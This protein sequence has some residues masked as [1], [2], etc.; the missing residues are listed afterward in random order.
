MNFFFFFFFGGGGEGGFFW[1]VR[2]GHRISTSNLPIGAYSI[3][4]KEAQGRG[5]RVK[6]GAT[7]K[8]FFFLP[9]IQRLGVCLDI[10]Y[11]IRL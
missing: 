2:F 9:Y 1:G 3:G 5:Q 10:R 6:G 7:R 4:K 11:D 8:F